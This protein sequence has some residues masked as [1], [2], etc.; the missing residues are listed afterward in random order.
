MNKLAFVSCLGFLCIGTL[1]AQEVSRF[2]FELGGGF[3]TPAGNTANYLDDGWNVQGGAGYNFSNHFGVMGRLDFNSMGMD[4]TAL[5]TS[6]FPGGYV[7]VF[8]A[9]LDPIVHLTPHSHFDLYAIGGGGL[10]HWAQQFNAPA[11]VA[12][13]SFGG[14]FPLVVPSAGDEYSVN[15]PGWNAGMGVAF[16]TKW[17]G[18]L[19]AEARY[20]HVFLN[21]VGGGERADYIPV[22][23]GFRW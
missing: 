17:H 3:T 7:H 18:K 21:G 22:T 6:G 4:G 11:G 2:S 9:T 5:G 10:Y 23:F 13:N 14:S 12:A 15:K 19:F 16:G 8:S 20:V 1:N